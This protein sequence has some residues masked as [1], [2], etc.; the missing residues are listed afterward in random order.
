MLSGAFNGNLVLPNRSKFMDWS[1][2]LV[3]DGDDVIE[4]SSAYQYHK[5]N[6][7]LIKLSAVLW[8]PS[9]CNVTLWFPVASPLTSSDKSLLELIPRNDFNSL[10]LL[11]ANQ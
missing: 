7:V 2:S 9:P 10:V 6:G 3:S 11:F 8:A 5:C 1:H 4:V